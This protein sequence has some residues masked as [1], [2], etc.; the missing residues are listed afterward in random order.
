MHDEWFQGRDTCADDTGFDF[1]NRPVEAR[2][3][4]MRETDAVEI[5]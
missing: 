5:V 3:T 2:N 4:G 1:H